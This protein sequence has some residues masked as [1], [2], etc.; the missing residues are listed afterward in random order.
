MLRIVNFWDSASPLCNFFLTVASYN[1]VTYGNLQ[2]INKP[3]AECEDPDET[4]A[5]P[6]CNEHVS[7]PSGKLHLHGCMET[8]LCYRELVCEEL[9]RLCP[10]QGKGL[11]LPVLNDYCCSEDNSFY[12]KTEST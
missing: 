5:I 9:G 3:N 12:D 4:Q 6:S 7:I 1:S 10:F 2:K 11:I 8:S